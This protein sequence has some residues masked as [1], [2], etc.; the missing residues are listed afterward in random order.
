MAVLASH[1]A[2]AK[3][4]PLV[5]PCC[6]SCSAD[7]QQRNEVLTL[8]FL[9]AQEISLTMNIDLLWPQ[10]LKDVWAWLGS[11]VTLS[12]AFSGPECF[13]TDDG[14]GSPF[15]RR[16]WLKACAPLVL[17]LL[18]AVVFGI[19]SMLSKKERGE[20]ERVSWQVSGSGYLWGK[21]SRNSV[22]IALSVSYIVLFF[23]PH[24]PQ[25]QGHLLVNAESCV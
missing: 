23:P 9:L 4:N 16:W 21:V 17:M 15:V 13:G 14:A 11:V 6:A 8:T 12:I 24:W 20:Q 5:P 10:V 1:L 2:H 22:C 19:R 25:L 7:I 18:H 3:T